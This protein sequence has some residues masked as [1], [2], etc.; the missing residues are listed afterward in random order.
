MRQPL[1]GNEA[2]PIGKRQLSHGIQFGFHK[3]P[4]AV[5]WVPCV[6]VGKHW[7]NYVQFYM[8]S[9]MVTQADFQALMGFNPSGHTG[10][11]LLPAESLTWYD[12]ALYC[13]A[14]SNG[15]ILIRFT[16][17]LRLPKRAIV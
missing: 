8:D 12:A 4:D 5:L 13:N 1:C 7:V 3:R 6:C 17:S 2:Y 10:N 16:N 9:T 15:T 11:G 14:R